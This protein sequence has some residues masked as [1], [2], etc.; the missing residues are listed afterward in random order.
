MAQ[1]D[2]FLQQNNQVLHPCK[3]RTSWLFPSERGLRQGDRLSPFLFILAMEGLDSLVRVAA[4]N[5]WIRGFSIKN[6]ANEAMNL[7]HLLYADEI[8]VF[9]E[10]EQEQICYLRVI[11]VVFEACSGLKVNWRK[12]SIFP[13]KEVQQ[14]VTLANILKCST[15]ELPT[16]Y[17]GMRLD[18][19]HK[20]GKI[21]D[22]ITEKTVKK[23]AIWKSQYS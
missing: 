1:L 7:T 9:C 21:W 8:V 19:K 22:G 6:K 16:I 11:L 17:L 3:W 2:D 12:S 13:I 4:Q 5:N 23:F 10:E 15:E 14:V 20:A 18:S